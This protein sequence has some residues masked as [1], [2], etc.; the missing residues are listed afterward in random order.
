MCTA[1]HRPSTHRLNW[2]AD[3]A[4][5]PIR[6]VI[7]PMWMLCCCRISKP[8]LNEQGVPRL[9]LSLA[10][11][12]EFLVQRAA[13]SRH[14]FIQSYIGTALIKFWHYWYASLLSRLCFKYML[15]KGCVLI[16]NLVFLKR[17]IDKPFRSYILSVLYFNKGE[18]CST[19]NILMCAACGS[20]TA[21]LR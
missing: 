20:N 10:N 9:I 14:R 5:W 18:C 3:C 4:V 8:M 13:V 11:W 16:A 12:L 1:L 6:K 2:Q 19:M 15:Y 7:W 17:E 21:P